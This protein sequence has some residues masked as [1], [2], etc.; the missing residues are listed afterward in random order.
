MMTCELNNW[1]Q[2]EV[3]V[4]PWCNPLWLTGLK[5]PTNTLTHFSI[6]AKKKSIVAAK[7]WTVALKLG[8]ERCTKCFDRNWQRNVANVPYLVVT[9][10]GYISDT[11][12]PEYTV[13]V[14]TKSWKIYYE[15]SKNRYIT[16]YYRLEIGPGPNVWNRSF[17]S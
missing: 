3:C 5:A 13:I 2:S 14:P 9:M 16:K 4:Q 8:P 15:T 10:T 1:I 6:L 11:I 7:K 12:L 17:Q